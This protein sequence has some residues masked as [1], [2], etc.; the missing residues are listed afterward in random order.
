MR[1]AEK[2]IN[3][4]RASLTKLKSQH[5]EIKR[6]FN[7]LAEKMESKKKRKTEV[8]ERKEKNNKG[9]E[10]CYISTEKLKNCPLCDRILTLEF[11]EKNYMDNADCPCGVSIK[12]LWDPEIPEGDE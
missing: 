4:H 2:K 7:K 6:K 1:A 8:I 3:E 5:T 11:S 9:E 10:N 12:I